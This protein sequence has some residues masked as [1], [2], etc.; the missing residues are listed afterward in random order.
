MAF[1]DYRSDLYNSFVPG[2][3]VFICLLQWQW[4]RCD[5]K[6]FRGK[7]KLSWDHSNEKVG[8]G[9]I[10]SIFHL[11]FTFSQSWSC[12]PRYYRKLFVCFYILRGSQAFWK[13][14]LTKNW[15]LRTW[16]QSPVITAI[17][18]DKD[19]NFLIK[20]DNVKRINGIFYFCQ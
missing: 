18:K 17:Y 14:A 1:F 6:A 8:Q 3:K 15:D 4:K 5:D 19:V 9:L 16:D 7:V 2:Y 12:E 13:K 20:N 10:T 11:L